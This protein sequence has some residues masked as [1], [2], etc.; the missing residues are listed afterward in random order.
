[1]E[2]YHCSVPNVLK[3]DN[4]SIYLQLEVFDYTMYGTHPGL[5]LGRCSSLELK[6]RNHC[7]AQKGYSLHIVLVGTDVVGKYVVLDRM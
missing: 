3:D 5:V 2:D 1:M 6:T 7:T 4:I